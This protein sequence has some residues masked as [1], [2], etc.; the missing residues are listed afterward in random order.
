MKCVHIFLKSQHMKPVTSDNVEGVDTCSWRVDTWNQTTQKVST[1]EAKCRHIATNFL[2]AE[3]YEL[4]FN[5]PQLPPMEKL[6]S[7]HYIQ[8][9]KCIYGGWTPGY[10]IDWSSRAAN[11]LISE[12]FLL[13]YKVESFHSYPS[14]LFR[15]FVFHLYNLHTL[16][17]ESLSV[18]LYKQNTCKLKWVLDKITWKNL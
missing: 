12:K 2:N 6:T 13:F 14:T 9:S 4:A 17:I 16:V 11:S 8:A 1:H 18:L 10:Y 3:M 15:E 7:G 5:E